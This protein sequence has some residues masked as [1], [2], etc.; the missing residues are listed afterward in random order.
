MSKALLEEA[1]SDGG[2]WSWWT[3]DLPDTVQ[4]EFVGTQLW[5]PPLTSDAPPNSQ[6]ALRFDDLNFVG[7][8]MRQGRASGLPHDWPERLHNDE[9]EPYSLSYGDFTLTDPRRLANFLDEAHDVDTRVGVVEDI[10]SISH[11]ASILAF[12]A[13][14]VGLILVA[15]SMTVL[16]YQGKVPL[17]EIEA[18]NQKWWD[19]WKEYWE[20]KHSPNPMPT[21]YACEVTIPAG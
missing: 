6:I 9:S 1:I 13:G 7:F 4:V 8:L 15:A 11:D 5:N 10:R 14:P 18:M 17:T 12:W 20:R 19:Y 3:A 21:D 2:L 16:N